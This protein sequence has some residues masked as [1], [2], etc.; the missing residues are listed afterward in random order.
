MGGLPPVFIEFIGHSK[1]VKT[2]VA[3]VKAELAAADSSGAGAFRK[4]GMLGKAAIAGIGIA[5]AAAA[6]KTV[7]MAA[8]F[9]TQMTRVRTGA[10]EAAAN[11][12]MVGQG[13]LAMAGQVG[14]S[15]S[16][17][18]AGLYT[19]ESAGYHGADALNV[20]KNAAMGAKVGA[21]DLH[22]VTDAVTTGLNAYKL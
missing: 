14:Q 18:T 12:K 3:D 2:A 4:T 13:V 17:L 19:V 6:V 9:Q 15:T 11:M 22:T 10:G 1:G 20:L 5:A 7:H 21:A 16:Q 8:D